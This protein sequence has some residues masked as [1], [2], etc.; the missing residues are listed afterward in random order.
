[1][2]FKGLIKN[3]LLKAV[4]DKS[5]SFEEFKQAHAHVD[6]GHKVGNVILKI[7]H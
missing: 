4:I 1:M 2:C 5:Y 6:S 7:K 3:N